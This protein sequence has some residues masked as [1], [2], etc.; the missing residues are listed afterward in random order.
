MHLNSK[1]YIAGHNGMV[2]S[3]IDRLLRKKGYTNL[4]KKTSSELDLRNQIKTGDF[5]KDYQPEYVFLAAAKVIKQIS[6][7]TT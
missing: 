3:A 6:C 7:M 2:G 1:I 4:V 5:F